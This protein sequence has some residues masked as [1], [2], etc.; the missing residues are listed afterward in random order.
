MSGENILRKNN[1]QLETRLH[2]GFLLSHHLELERFNSHFPMF[3]LSFQKATFGQKRWEKKYDYPLLGISLLY[4]DLGRYKEIGNAYAVFPY[5]NFPLFRKRK[6]SY[7]F[8][9]GLGLA[10]LENKFDKLNNYKNFAI[11]SHLNIVANLQFEY[12]RKINKRL[13]FSIALTLT[14]FSNGTTK[15]PNYGL[16]IFTTNIAIAY[17]LAKPRSYGGIKLLPEL[18]TFEFDGRKYLEINAIVVVSNKDMSQEIGERFMVYASF[19]NIMKRVSYK[20]KF[21]LGFDITADLSDEY[22][23]TNNLSNTDSN[24]KLS[25]VKTGIS[26]AYELVISRTSFLF[27]LGLYIGGKI[28]KHGDAYQRLTLKYLINKNLT[29]NLALSTHAGTA[30][31]IGIG[32]GYRLRFI[33]ARKIKHY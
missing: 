23:L 22:F 15:T 3:E 26:G 6:S 13:R 16:N 27:N 10:Y 2:Y 8:R 24:N 11:G 9:L 18:Y 1:I 14:H 17:S 4:S 31:Y 25:F 30:D 19:F 32:L 5:I 20:S 7:N 12:R 33:Y 28:R 29:A 21:G